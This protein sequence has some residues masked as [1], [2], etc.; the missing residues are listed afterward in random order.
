MHN[1]LDGKAITGILHFINQ[2]PFD[3]Y[4]KKQATAEPAT[5]GAEELAGRAAI[6]QCRANRLTFLYLGVPIEGPSILLGDNES[7]VKGV[8]IPHRRLNKRHLM[9]SWHYLREAISPQVRMIMYTFLAR[10]ILP[11]SLASIGVIVMFG[12]C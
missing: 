5:Y 7:V 2:T 3:W 1:I 6:E 11:T 8:T 9:L 12:V 4:S 10:S